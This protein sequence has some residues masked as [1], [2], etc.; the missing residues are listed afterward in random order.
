MKKLH[1]KKVAVIA[2]T[3]IKKVEE[4]VA[5]PVKTEEQ[6]KV[7]EEVEVEVKPVEVVKEEPKVE[8]IKVE[9]VKEEPKKEEVK[10]EP[11]PVKVEEKVETPE[12]A[13]VDTS[14]LK[15]VMADFA[16]QMKHLSKSIRKAVRSIKAPAEAAPVTVEP[17]VEVE[18]V[19]TPKEEVKVEKTVTPPEGTSNPELLA[20]LKKIQ[21][22]LKQLEDSPAPSKVIIS[23]NYLTETVDDPKSELEKVEARLSELDKIRKANPS[24]FIDSLQT[25]AFV[26]INKR[27]A[28]K[29]G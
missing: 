19:E 6:P 5:E 24:E 9:P 15:E 20:E 14:E 2:D 18:K 27:D 1:K 4:V 7:V 17:K 29:Q 3:E 23:K 8:P 25:E 26:L 12:M 16:K 22:R 10:T 21:E 28:L 13:K 11:E